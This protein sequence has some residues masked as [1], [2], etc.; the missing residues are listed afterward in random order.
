MFK[1]VY[2]LYN[3]SLVLHS[4]GTLTDQIKNSRDETYYDFRIYA[5]IK[6]KNE[7]I[8]DVASSQKFDAM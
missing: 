3:D 7:M 5:L 4:Y 2:V 1:R 8:L 6:D